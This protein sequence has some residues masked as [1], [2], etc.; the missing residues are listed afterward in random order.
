MAGATPNH[1]ENGTYVGKDIVNGNA[2]PVSEDTAASAAASPAVL[3]AGVLTTVSNGTNGTI[4][5]GAWGRKLSSMESTEGD[6]TKLSALPVNGVGNAVGNTVVGEKAA[7]TTSSVVSSSSSLS[8]SL[9]TSSVIGGMHPAMVDESGAGE[10]S[11]ERVGKANGAGRKGEA[12]LTMKASKPAKRARSSNGNATGDTHSHSNGASKGRTR[13]GDSKNI[14]NTINTAAV[15]PAGLEGP[16][17]PSG[18]FFSKRQL[19]SLSLET[20]GDG[21]R[22]SDAKRARSSPN[23]RSPRGNGNDQ[24]ASRDRTVA[25]QPKA[26]GKPRSMIPNGGGPAE[27]NFSTENANGSG[28]SRGMNG[29]VLVGRGGERGR[30]E[31]AGSKAN[32]HA[33]GHKR[34]DDHERPNAARG[35]GVGSVAIKAGGG[36]AAAAAATVKGATNGRLL[37]PPS[38][39]SS[40]S[41][42]SSLSSS[43]GVHHPAPSTV[44][45]RTEAS[46]ANGAAHA[47]EDIQVRP[48]VNGAQAAEATSATAA[49]VL[50]EKAQQGVVLSSEVGTKAGAVGPARVPTETEALALSDLKRRSTNVPLRL[51]PRERWAM[52]CV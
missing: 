46:S 32:G 34:H 42:P 1:A 49:A 40:S 26:K 2:A 14:S 39:S 3:S 4:D 36:M 21:T 8:L 16:L 6:D 22:E 47:K 5:E 51:D 35:N 44:T 43:S 9:S 10:A 27:K 45:P 17:C 38:T 50:G 7:P 31:A 11:K 33:N 30:R 12:A 29:D 13:E 23:G 25:G 37:P 52:T 28:V 15:R 19:P 41:L 48:M 24:G 20:G 18:L